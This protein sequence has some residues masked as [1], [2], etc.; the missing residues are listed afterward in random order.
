MYKNIPNFINC[1]SPQY[2]ANDKMAAGSPG[3]YWKNVMVL[4]GSI[5]V[6]QYMYINTALTKVW[7]VFID[8]NVFLTKSKKFVFA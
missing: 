2:A 1:M 8:E 4:L 6:S 7:Q 5:F 3:Q